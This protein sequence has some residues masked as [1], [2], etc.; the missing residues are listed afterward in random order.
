MNVLFDM[1]T[2]DPDDAVTLCFLIAHPLVSLRAVTVTPGTNEQVGLVHHILQTTNHAEIPVGSYRPKYEKNC[3]SAFHRRWLGN[4]DDQL[5]DAEG[6]QVIKETLEAYPDLVI[7]TGAPLKNFGALEV[8]QP[9][10]KWIAQGGFAGDNVVPPM[11]RLP[12]FNGMQF[13]PTYNFNGA[14]NEA[15]KMLNEVAINDRFLVSKNVCHGVVYNEE[16]HELLT[17]QRHLH[18]GYEL[19]YKG[20]KLYLSK[21]K[22]GK[23]FH[24]PLAACVAIDPDIC[25]FKE[26]KLIKKGG[27]WGSEPQ[28]GTNTYISIGVD[29]DKFRK[30]FLQL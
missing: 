21:K 6:H 18:L 12:K 15:L 24:D 14:P 10:E 1:E 28:E 5:P 29:Q 27:K 9:I 30:V 17:P 3:L 4:F 11:H 16:F 20:M 25:I 8:N 19:I 2:G 13:C 7:I 23:K 26:V 22:A